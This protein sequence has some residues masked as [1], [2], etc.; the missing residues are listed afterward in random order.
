MI[1]KI[2]VILGSSAALMVGGLGVG[3]ASAATMAPEQT[4]QQASWHPRDFCDDWGHRGDWRCR[5]ENRWN[6]DGH[7]W[8]HYRW[9]G[10]G[11]R[12]YER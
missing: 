11:H 12:W 6:W 9:D 10:R 7:R 3:S 8:H 5:S 4:T 1:R 2:A